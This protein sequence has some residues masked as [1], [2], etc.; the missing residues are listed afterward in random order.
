MRIVYLSYGLLLPTRAHNLQ[1]V[2]T[3]DALIA[4]GHRV[5]FINPD[6]RPDAGDAN[7]PACGAVVL[8]AG[9]CFPRHRKRTAI[10]RFWSLFLDRTAFACRALPHVRAAAPDAVIT[11]DVVICFWLLALRW[12]LQ[13][14]VIYELHTLEQFMF[15]ADDATPLD[16]V[17]ARRVDAATQTD[18]AGHQ[19]DPSWAGRLY[20][21]FIRRLENH[22]LRRVPLVIVLTAAVSRRL[23][24]GLGVRRS[25]VVPSGHRLASTRLP[26]RRACRERL[27]LPP[28]AGLAIYAGLSL[29]GKGLDLVIAVARRLPPDC[30]ILV[31]GGDAATIARLA[32]IA[33]ELHVTQL[34]FRPM[35]PHQ[36][37][38]DYLH[39]ADLGLLLY[40]RTRYLA[41]FSSPL[42]LFEYLACGLPVVATALPALQE[43]VQD[44]VN[45]RIVPEDDPAAIAEVIAATARDPALLAS[46]RAGA[47]ASAARYGYAERARRI[48]HA[49]LACLEQPLVAREGR[50]IST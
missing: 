8:P 11:R 45:G 23:G 27:G 7:L 29:H 26:E 17:L 24:E 36:H 21:R 33:A 2:G 49:V 9:R 50:C 6:L 47:Q 30:V 16:P 5:T 42:K 1:T 31:L 19:D 37:V 48:E 28:N 18:F 22:V 44:G 3:I 14:P 43:I 10:G 25:C 41:E 20:K 38:A 39:A 12:L 32:G 40:N 15:D 34:M 13:A 46:L 4:R 35:V